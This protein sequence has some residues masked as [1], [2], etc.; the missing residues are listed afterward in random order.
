MNP[1]L[2]RQLWFVVE[3]TQ[4]RSLAQLDDQSLTRLLLTDVCDLQPLDADELQTLSLYIHTKLSL[5]RDLAE[6]RV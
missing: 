6:C 1:T 3:T 5:I 4:P 2:L